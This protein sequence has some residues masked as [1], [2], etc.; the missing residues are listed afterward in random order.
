M[1]KWIS[2]KERL[3]PKNLRKMFYSNS[4]YPFFGH[5]I[6]SVYIQDNIVTS[7]L[8]AGNW[9]VPETYKLDEISHWTE[10]PEPPEDE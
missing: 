6:Y 1:T 5:M 7:V 10:L 4:G 2:V 8:D 9:N 3:P